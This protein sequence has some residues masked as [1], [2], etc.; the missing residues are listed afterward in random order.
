MRLS[1]GLFASVAWKRLSMGMKSDLGTSSTPLVTWWSSW[2][3]DECLD[4]RG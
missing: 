1:S 4:I 3:V 2:G